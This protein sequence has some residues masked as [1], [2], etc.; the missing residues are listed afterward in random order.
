MVSRSA[1]KTAGG[2]SEYFAAYDE[3]MRLWP[4]PFEDV[5]V[6]SRF[7]STHVVV[8]GPP[9]GDAL[10]LLHG[11]MV[12]AAMWSPNVGDLCRRHRVYA[13]DTMGQP[14]K[15]LPADPMGEPAD[16]VEWL[17]AVLD[18][19]GLDDVDLAGM[20]FGAWIALNFAMAAPNRVRRLVLLSP[21]ASLQPLVRQFGLRGMMAGI[22]PTRRMAASLMRWMGFRETPG[23]EI[24]TRLI[25]LMWLGMRDF[26]MPPEA[27]RLI[28]DAFPDDA[29]RS[30]EMPVLLLLGENEVIYDPAKALARARRLIANLD[31]EL[32]PDC[33]HDMSI[34]RAQI[35]NRRILGFLN[36]AGTDARDGRNP[37]S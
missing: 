37:P 15:N 19:L 35:V 25:E 27:R 23:N 32:I 10:V 11:F 1:F 6:P 9:D 22:F 21:A 4:V 16:L 13:V 20:S 14:G 24:N 3:A 31:G 8:S 33:S 7:G 28:P 36:E 12:T 30:L 5:A 17:A 26:R 34:S 18:G 2:E 29:L